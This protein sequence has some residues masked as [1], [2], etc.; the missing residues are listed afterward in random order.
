MLIFLGMNTTAA[1]DVI[2]VKA[3]FPPLFIFQ[4]GKLLQDGLCGAD[5]GDNTLDHTDSGYFYHGFEILYQRAYCRSG[6]GV[7]NLNKGEKV[8]RKLKLWEEGNIPLWDP[9]I[10][11]DV[12]SISFMPAQGM[13]TPAMIICPGGS[14]IYEEMEKEG[15]KIGECLNSM[16][17]S[18]FVLGYRVVPYR[19]PCALIDIQRAIRYVR[20]NADEL[21][22]DPERVA[23]IGFSAGGHLAAMAATLFTG[24]E[25]SPADPVDRFSNRPD[26][27]VLCYAPLNLNCDKGSAG[28][29]E[30]LYGTSQ[31]SAEMLKKVS[32][33]QNVNSNMPSAFI[34]TTFGDVLVMPY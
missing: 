12:P 10:C 4:P 26:L 28:L 16:G 5:D 11:Q 9:A 13:K 20:C 17:I 22:I 7:I 15:T 23:V 21:S 25:Y 6:K 33:A 29:A 18:S 34:C 30:N 24:C 32:P 27:V 2:S 14:Y 3:S 8:M 31:V 1:V 19:H